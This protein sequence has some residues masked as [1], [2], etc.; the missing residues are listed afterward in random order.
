M[1]TT[2][3]PVDNET[4]D[5]LQTLTSKLEAI[6]TYQKYSQDAQG[7][8]KQAF[9]EMA[10]QDRQ[11]AER[12]VQLLRQRLGNGSSSA[13]SLSSTGPGSSAGA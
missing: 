7:D 9:Q 5:L 3:F 8:A 11:H 4:Y 10:Q 13:G 2:S 12:L 6:E 1:G